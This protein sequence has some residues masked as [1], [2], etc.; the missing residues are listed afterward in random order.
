MPEPSSRNGLDSRTEHRGTIFFKQPR[1][2]IMT[3]P[4]AGL[5][6][7]SAKI[8][9]WNESHPIGTEV[10]ADLYPQQV[11]RTRTQAMLLFDCKA[12]IYLDGLRGYFDLE[13]VHPIHQPQAGASGTLEVPEAGADAAKRIAVVFPGQGAQARGMGNTLFAQFPELTRRADE[14]LG[15]SIER[16]CV[17]DADRNL[18]RTQFTQVAL[19][20]V[21]ALAY[22]EQV[23]RNDR[24]A[25][26]AFYLGHSL[27]EYNAL[28]AAEVFDFET[29]LQLVKKR[30]EIMAAVSGG[31]MAAVIGT[32]ADRLRSVLEQEK[33][34]GI[35]LANFNSPTQIVISGM[36]SAI[37]QACQLLAARKINVVP[38]NLSG[39]FHSR[40][41]RE[42]QDGFAE[43]LAQFSFAAPRRPV[44]ANATARPYEPG[45]VAQTLANQ[46]ANPVLWVDSVRH[47][48][49]QGPVEFIE[50]GS[51]ILTRMINEIGA[52][53]LPV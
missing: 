13:H 44:I 15:Y 30:G 29:G 32:D 33:I 8:R 3:V 36:R 46:I 5:E 7:L 14:I 53:P 34:E 25:R 11:H 9:H 27:G 24:S 35:D 45:D 26:A 39:P 2:M 37:E 41:M 40:Y 31:A 43:F 6:R 12:G 17:E 42:A 21:N 18:S 49:R 20:V 50:I 38:L 10:R 48:L 47:V 23:R 22:I 19:Y 16:L 51:P 1:G 52:A 28:L 4:Q